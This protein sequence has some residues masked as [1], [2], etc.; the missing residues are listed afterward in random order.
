MNY[1]ILN[2]EIITNRDHLNISLYNTK[3]N[4][5][6][7]NEH[8]VSL[9][10]VSSR[11]DEMIQTLN[12]AKRK[13]D[14]A[15]TFINK[16]KQFG[17]ALCNDLI[18]V[19]IKSKLMNEDAEYLILTIDNHLVHI[20][21]ELIIIDDQFLCEKFSMGRKIKTPQKF[22]EKDRKQIRNPLQMMI[23][24]NPRGDLK[25][26]GKEAL[27]IHKDLSQEK[28]IQVSMNAV[29]STDDLCEKFQNYDI[30]HFAGHAEYHP[31]ASDKS[32]WQMAGSDVLTAG[33]IYQMT[34]N[35]FMPSLV[36]SNACQSA[37]TEKW[38]QDNYDDYGLANAFMASGVSAYIGSHW[39]I[40]DESGR[41]FAQEFYKNI[42][43]GCSVG[44]SIKNTRLKL[45]QS[46]TDIDWAAYVLYG[47]P[48]LTFITDSDNSNITTK[49][50][51]QTQLQTNQPKKEKFSLNMIKELR[52]WFTA[53][54]VFIICGAGL[55]F[56]HNHFTKDELIKVKKILI[57]I[58]NQKQQRI[59]SLF[60]EL[61]DIGVPAKK[62]SKEKLNIELLVDSK[63]ENTATEDMILAVIQ[64]KFVRH[65]GYRI[66]ESS[67]QSL[68]KVLETLVNRLRLPGKKQSIEFSMPDI[69]IFI[70]L[71]N[72]GSKSIVL[73]RPVLANN[74][75]LMHENIFVEL[76]N[77]ISIRSQKDKLTKKL[78]EVLSYKN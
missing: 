60:K 42:M 6:G 45:Q 21:W 43:F 47:D 13:N 54:I 50:S 19:E 3:S 56:M 20:P 5:I 16:V 48:S 33:R 14:N 67:G 53:I 18:S 24:A 8:P 58:A 28:M 68:D 36:F 39:D 70:A 32:G 1:K 69:I 78:S 73:L 26:A 17:L 65:P 72:C 37:R 29:I 59:N 41:L 4:L 11:C 66:I 75:N 31:E 57:T 55:L 74:Q 10:Q 7:C 63:H 23:I 2:F 44:K 46:V 77:S 9:D 49:F 61:A 12:T 34:G 51:D 25:S 15:G 62:S 22:I 40:N 76:D 71:Y 38:I 27:E 30:I 35:S 52:N 64:N